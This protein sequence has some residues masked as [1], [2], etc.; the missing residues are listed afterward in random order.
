MHARVIGLQ[1]LETELKR[2]L[3]RQEFVIHYQPIVALDRDRI[4]GFE[5]LLRWRHPEK[6]LI[7]PGE[8]IPVAEETGVIVPLGWWTLRTACRQMQQWCRDFPAH[9]GMS[10]SVNISERQFSEP[11]MVAGVQRILEETGLP[12]NHLCLEVTE[13]LLLEHVE[14]ALDKLSRLQRLGVRL[15]LDD[16]GTGYS[17]LS[18]LQKF[19]YDSLKI[20]RSFVRTLDGTEGSSAIVKTIIALGNMMHIDVIAEGVESLEQLASLRQM[21][22][23]QVQGFYF[24]KPLGQESVPGLLSEDS[25]SGDAGADPNGSRPRLQ[26]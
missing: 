3:E 20:D 25:L 22:C 12:A 2:A 7:P 1:Q 21:E 17:S 19:S 16:F 15:H 6:G 26:S 10:L 23:P 9:R 18:Y 4:Q 11:D 5:A 14:A 24:S 13:S 8:F